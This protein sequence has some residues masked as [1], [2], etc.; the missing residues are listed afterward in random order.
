MRKDDKKLGMDRRIDRRDFLNGASMSAAAVSAMTLA[1]PT[2]AAPQPGPQDKPGYYP[3]SLNG[4]RGS[5][6]GSFD[7]AHSVRDGTFWNTAEKMHDTDGVYDLVIVGAGISGLSA[8][9]FYRAAKPNAKVLILDNHDD[10]GGHARRNEY[11]LN[12][13]LELLNGG[14]ELIDSPRPYSAVASGLLK[15]LGIE[16]KALAAKCDKPEI[17]HGLGVASFFDKETFGVDRLVVGGSAREEDE[18]VDWTAFLSKTPLSPKQRSDML[19][20][21]AGTEDYFPGLTSDQ[22]KDKLSRM[23]YL[24]YLSKVV[25]ADPKTV[26]YYQKITHDEWGVGIDAEP[27]LDCWGFGLPGFKGLKLAP[28]STKRMGNTAAGYNE[29]TFD[30]FHFPDGNASIARLLVRALVPKA[31]PGHTAEDVVTATAAYNELDREGTPVRIRLSS[32]V[33]GVRNLGSPKASKGV[34]LAYAR[35]GRVWRLHTA[36]CILASWNMMIP[37]LCSDMPDAQKAALHE[38]VKVPLLYTSVAIRNWTAFKKLGVQYIYAPGGYFSSTRLNWPVD[39]GGYR[40]VR[41]PNDPMLLFMVRTPCM[42]GLPEKD[43]HRAGRAELLGTEFTDFEREIRGQL[44]RMLKDGGFD[45]KKDI[46]AITVNR[47]GHGY[48]YEYNP[49]FDDFDLPP[50]KQ[51]HIVGRKR[52]GRIAIANSDSGAAAYTDS[53]IDQARR[54]V[55]EILALKA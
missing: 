38:L 34:E 52:W 49:L 54:A 40:S 6:P 39:I 22:K 32:T 44:G 47:W 33:V 1:D 27:A 13:K 10:F 20:I 21:E 35:G 3:P 9:F 26:A 37:Y 12:G 55:D 31:M 8:A 16:P 36:N 11:H 51:P 15:S 50:E 23:S 14:T 17:Y 29:N 53:A 42:P 25:K 41:S 48:A 19:K 45:P 28:G 7:I 30:T 18:T 24:D 5:H 2:I 4:I 43:Q 46:T